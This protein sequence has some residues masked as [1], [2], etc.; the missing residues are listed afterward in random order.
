MISGALLLNREIE[1]VSF[2]KK[3]D[4][5]NLPFYILFSNSFH[6]PSDF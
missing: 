2:I 3:M 5:V 1:L 6:N 4:Q